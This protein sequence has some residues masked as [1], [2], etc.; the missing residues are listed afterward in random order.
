MHWMLAQSRGTAQAQV[1]VWVIVLI[2]VVLV[3]FAV[4]YLL[5]KKL[6]G[7]R[8]ESADTEGLMATMRRMKERGEMSPE[9]YEQAR[10]ALS[11]KSV[12][13]VEARL[14]AR[15]DKNSDTAK[16]E[17]AKAAAQ[18]IIDAGKPPKSE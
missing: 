16:R 17:A 10:R 8:Q 4:L 9:E 15:Q 1:V 7:D 18:K 6:F 2:V 5:H 14:A 12:A 3:A 13:D 11:R